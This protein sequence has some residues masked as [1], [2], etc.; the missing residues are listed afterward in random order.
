MSCEIHNE[1]FGVCSEQWHLSTTWCLWAEGWCP[2][3]ITL[4]RAHLERLTSV[5]YHRPVQFRCSRFKYHR[6][7]F[8]RKITLT[9]YK[10]LWHKRGQQ[11]TQASEAE[12]LIVDFIDN[13]LNSFWELCV[14]FFF[15]NY[16]CIAPVYFGLN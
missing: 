7:I 14:V 5:L 15:I 12:W 11:Q 16:D 4:L 9:K 1:L 2:Q 8:C 3:L 10:L 6:T 13:W